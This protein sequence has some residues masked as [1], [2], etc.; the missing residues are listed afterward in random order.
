MNVKDL[1]LKIFQMTLLIYHI[2]QGVLRVYHM[3]IEEYFGGS[4]R[5]GN[6]VVVHRPKIAPIEE[7][8]SRV[9][10]LVSD[11]RNNDNSITVEQHFVHGELLELHR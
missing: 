4:I 3:D 9:S 6:L 7:S 2:I 10:N 1:V 5:V 8:K 11:G